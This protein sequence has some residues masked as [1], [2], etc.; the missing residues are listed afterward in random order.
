[1]KAFK[2]HIII[3]QLFAIGAI[4][5]AIPSLLPYMLML[6]PFVL[7]LTDFLALSPMLKHKNAKFFTW[8]I[9]TYAITFA[10]EVA[11]VKTGIIFGEYTYGKTLGPKLFDVPVVIGFNWV[12]VILGGIML[13]RKIFRHP[14]LWIIATGILAFI[15][16]YALEPVAI[17][18]DYWTWG[19]GVVPIK[20]Y[21]A[22][23]CVA[24]IGAGLFHVSRQKVTS[25]VPIHFFFVQF[26]FFIILNIVL[27]LQGSTG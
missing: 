6:T 19:G 24:C 9:V 23:F 15:F 1:M 10:V 2:P 3:Y 22:W 4:G 11:G 12:M 5:H 26:A 21:V 8:C 14:L 25:D 27:A 18:L 7:V 20:N 16:D 13:S 17:K